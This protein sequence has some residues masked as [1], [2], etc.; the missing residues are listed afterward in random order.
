MTIC[1]F[2]GSHKTKVETKVKRAHN[3]YAIPGDNMD[4][5]ISASVRC[6]K[7]HARGPV[8]TGK[9]ADVISTKQKAENKWNS[10]ASQVFGFEIEEVDSE[11]D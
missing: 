1:P 6:N 11:D 9:R 10:W 2:C 4:D 3:P 8:V 7:C 5:R